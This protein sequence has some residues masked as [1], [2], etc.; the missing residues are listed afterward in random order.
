MPVNAGTMPAGS[1][2]V[3]PDG[4]AFFELANSYLAGQDQLRVLEA[5][6]LARRQHGEQR[7]QS[8]ELFLTHPL[9]VAYYLAEYRA[10]ASALI[11]ALLHDVAEDTVLS[12]EEISQQFGPEVSQL[13]DG[14]T[15]LKEV[16]AGV[17]K[18]RH[19]TNQEI[20]DASLH[21]MFAAMTA[22]VRVVLIKLF[23][24]LHNMRTLDA[25]PPAKQ[26]AKAQETLA[27]YAPLAN[28]LGI[29]RI[30]TELEELSLRALDP[31][32]YKL[33]RV[34]LDNQFHQHQ[35]AYTIIT[36]QI[37]KHL[38]SQGLVVSD[39]VQNPESVYS[40]YRLYQARGISIEKIETP[41]RVVVLVED[42]IS[43]YQALGHLHNLWRPVPGK[44]DDYIALPR[45]NHY[46]ALHTTVIY[47]DGQPL[48]I[49]IRTDAMNIAS[50]IGVLARWVYAGTPLWTH[51]VADR[52]NAMLASVSQN[53]REE[54]RDLST[55][56]KVVVDDVF[57]QQIMVYTPRG[58][59]IELPQ[60]ATPIDFAFAIHSEVGTQC[61]IAYVNEQPTAL[62][63][64]LNDGDQVRIVKSG[65]ARPQRTWLDEDLG[66]LATTQA[67]SRVRR[68]FRRLPEELALAEGRKILIDEL[69]MLGLELF[70]HDRLAERLDYETPSELYHALGRAELLPTELATSVLTWKWHQEPERQIGSLVR[71][72][73]GQEF[74]V[75]NG[76]GRRLRLCRSCQARPGDKIVGFLRT[77]GGVTVHK[78]DCY[79]LRP[80]P[81]ADRTIRLSWSR[82]GH[83][84]VRTVTVEVD[85][86]DRS[87]LLLEIAELLQDEE[88]NIASIVTTPLDKAKLRVTLDLEMASPRLLVRIL[89]R[90]HALINVYA[91]RCLRS[92]SETVDLG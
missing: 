56:V 38:Q 64:A 82:D 88:V 77:D 43:C 42:A 17:V 58:D 45:E 69:T 78:E 89:H 21:K 39:V 30:K 16:S 85:V 10:D 80:D 66:Y 36:E 60:G 61:L 18:G 1:L 65:W 87:G 2:Y 37:I 34:A 74:V 52:V 59:V 47:S 12:I 83:D 26:K 46:R 71:T 3:S 9:T 75:T 13:V 86:Y 14:V 32:A 35:A 11:A 54:A 76:G 29:W 4:Q 24:R 5:F 63:Q 72:D 67:R 53:I 31:E 79:T 50:E 84:T 73:S 51:G 91:V 70:A 27:V 15:K 81:M 22:D 41:M 90:V 8:G 33:I 19:L 55:G 20:Q 57:R 7:R 48:K 44:F 92:S 6:D 40:I 68:W 25:L 23:D 28:R 49:R 62:N